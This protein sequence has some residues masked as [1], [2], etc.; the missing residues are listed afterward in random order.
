LGLE[1]IAWPIAA[2]SEDLGLLLAYESGADIIVAVGTHN[3]LVDHLDKG[4]K[5]MASTFLIRL[6]VGP[7][8][9]DAKGVS[10]L[11]RASPSP[12]QLVLLGLA[13]VFAVAVVIII[14]PGVR[15]MI[16]LTGLTGPQGDA[17]ATGRDGDQFGE[18]ASRFAGFTSTKTNGAAGGRSGRWR[19]FCTIGTLC[20]TRR[21]PM[22]GVPPHHSTAVKEI[23]NASPDAPPPSPAPATR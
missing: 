9:V 20:G 5:G 2:M 19:R 11:Y 4:R 18:A 17:G 10:R 8:L 16:G 6:K 21:L 7:K 3:N 12:G 14:S 23:A 15:A 22:S 1:A 13:G